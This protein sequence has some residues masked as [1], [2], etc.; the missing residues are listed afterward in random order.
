MNSSNVLIVIPA[1]GGSKGVPRKNLRPLKGRPL[2]Y[3][4]IKAALSVAGNPRV[5]VSTDDEEIALFARRFGAEILMR[6]PEL[7]D[8]AVTM[9]PVIVHAVEESE[10][11]WQECYEVVITVQPTSPLVLGKDIEEV[12]AMFVADGTVETVMSAVDDRHL[13]W[14]EQDGR[15]VPDYEKRV[16]RQQ[17]PPTFRETGAVIACQRQVL[18][19]GTRIG[20]N[21]KL[22]LMDESRSIDIDTMRDIWL[23]EQV[24]SRK[25]IVINVIGNRQTGLGHAFRSVML[26]HELVG[27]D[28]VFVCEAGDDLAIEYINRHNYP[29]QLCPAGE[30]LDEICRLSPKMVIND[31]LDTSADF[32]IE[33]KKRGM[34]VVN[35]EDMGLGA[36]VADLVINALYPHQ[37]PS[38]HIL[39]GPRYFC[40]R[41]EFLHIQPRVH[42][43]SMERLLVAFGGVDEA[44]LTKRVLEV[45]GDE[46]SA[47]G[48]AI[49]VILGPGYPYYEDL[50][51]FVERLNA[52]SISII[53]STPRISD[54]MARADMAVT[55]GGRTVLELTALHVPVIILCQ[56]LRETTHKFSTSEF[57]IINLGLSRD[58]SD[59]QIRDTIFKVVES[60]ELRATMR[61]KSGKLNLREGKRRVVNR[62]RM[63]LDDG[64]GEL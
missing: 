51:A 15:I 56:N 47:R 63:L 20:S 34:T 55:S 29:L 22:Y 38:E 9:D 39:V 7:A 27:Y 36:E 61:R 5:V 16:N 40:L 46:L 45:V 33:L 11:R 60:A 62:I 8:D 6:P 59:E 4:S 23:C 17:L 64:G 43:D 58:V 24:L 50:V 37:I 52:P 54:Y 35:F 2:I 31:I 32:V 25:K 21:I 48:I 13:R 19:A 14:R 53:K 57:G 1:R 41:D 3:Y 30:R 26:A 49:D 12:L 10:N 18:A 28:V 42:G 44:N